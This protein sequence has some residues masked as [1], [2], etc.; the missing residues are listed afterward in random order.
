MRVATFVISIVVVVVMFFQSCAVYGLSSISDT[1]GG[2]ETPSDITSGGALGIFVTILAFL[3]MAFVL[4]LPA[5]SVFLY[6][7]AT[8]FAFLSASTGFSDMTIW[9]VVLAVLTLFSIL[10]WREQKKARSEKQVPEAE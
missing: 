1:L 6:A 10:A 8:I 9:G 5:V 2:Q 4:K 3:G 7:I